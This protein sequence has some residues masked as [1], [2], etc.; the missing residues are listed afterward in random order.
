MTVTAGTEI[1][2]ITVAVNDEDANVEFSELPPGVV[3]VPD[4]REITGIPET[5]G[6]YPVTVTATDQFGREQ[7]MSFTMTV[8]DAPEEPDPEPTD[9]P[10][11]SD[12]PTGEPT[13]APSVDPVGDVDDTGNGNDTGG[14]SG[15]PTNG[16][17]TAAD[18]DDAQGG[19]ATTDGETQATS[20]GDRLAN[21]GV[22]STAI[23]VVGALALL[24]L[25]TGAIML[26]R[27]KQ[28]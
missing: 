9:E 2:P 19:S 5:A 18:D 17:G 28:A 6:E 1:E 21:T 23:L 22:G 8:E 7:Q 15:D 16:A 10:E 11:P 25:G 14:P 20:F 4:G 13:D 24:G 26:P 12:D 27:R 3:G